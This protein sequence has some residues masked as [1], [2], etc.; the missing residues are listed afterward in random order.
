MQRKT[1][2]LIGR[3]TNNPTSGHFA[4][5][6][7]ALSLEETVVSIVFEVWTLYQEAWNTFFICFCVQNGCKQQKINAWSGVMI[8]AANINRFVDLKQMTVIIIQ[9]VQA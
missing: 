2:L 9:K 4:E 8:F 3:H 5:T 1:N 6:F 7:A